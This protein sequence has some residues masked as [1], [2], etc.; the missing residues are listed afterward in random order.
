[1]AV[2]YRIVT[3]AVFFIL[4]TNLYLYNNT[5]PKSKRQRLGSNTENQM[6]KK[7]SGL[8]KL[9]FFL[10]LFFFLQLCK[11]AVDWYA[12][13]YRG[14]DSGYLVTAG[15]PIR[16]SGSPWLV[17]HSAQLPMS[18]LR[19]FQ[20]AYSWFFSFYIISLPFS[21]SKFWS[22]VLLKLCT[23]Y[24]CINQHWASLISTTKACP[25]SPG[26]SQWGKYSVVLMISYSLHSHHLAMK[27]IE[28]NR[29]VAWTDSKYCVWWMR[30]DSLPTSITSALS[31]GYQAIHVS[32]F[33]RIIEN[34]LSKPQK[35]ITAA[36]MTATWNIWWLAPK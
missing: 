20:A 27:K 33:D 2:K 24:G 18:A 13:C 17:I 19:A 32:I 11:A 22:V 12:F 3:D 28:R 10:V 30:C 31:E 5:I 29:E 6:R 7:C 35:C 36:I 16:L 25:I 23:R 34:A 14:W 4:S 9:S 15:S 8:P 21:T 1:M 26:V